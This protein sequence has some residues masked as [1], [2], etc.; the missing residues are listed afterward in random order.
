MPVHK[1]LVS[2]VAAVE[3]WRTRRQSVGG[4]LAGADCLSPAGKASKLRIARRR[5]LHEVVQRL[6]GCGPRKQHNQQ[7]GKRKCAG[8]FEL[9]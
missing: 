2:Y 7:N 3:R 8:A 6:G 9:K 5:R 1:H 4:I